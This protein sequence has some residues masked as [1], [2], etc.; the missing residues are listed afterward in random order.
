MNVLEFLIDCEHNRVFGPW[1][2]DDQLVIFF[3]KPPPRRIGKWLRK[4]KPKLLPMVR[5]LS[6]DGYSM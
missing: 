3:Q 1:R 2:D 4:L 6:Q 5:R